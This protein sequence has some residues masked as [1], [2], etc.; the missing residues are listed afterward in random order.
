MA[1][2][3]PF[4][5]TDQFSMSTFNSKLGGAFGKV[6]ADV[7]ALQTALAHSGN[8]HIA[9]GS[10]VGT[11][12]YGSSNPCSLTFDFQPLIV[13]LNTGGAN[14]QSGVPIQYMMTRPQTTFCYSYNET[15]RVAW[16]ENGVTWYNK[17]ADSQ[18]NNAD[19]IY[20]YIA[21]GEKIT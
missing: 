20:Y 1:S 21:I 15:G 7:N 13:F 2:F 8:C 11:G 12:L 5:G 3:T 19:R 16:S 6:D 14:F 9:I 17:A 4:V 18:L 10:Y